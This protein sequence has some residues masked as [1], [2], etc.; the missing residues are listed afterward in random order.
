MSAQESN[1]FAIKKR[2]GWGAVLVSKMCCKI[3]TKYIL[4]LKFDKG[5]SAIT[6]LM[7]ISNKNCLKNP[8]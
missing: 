7:Q 1:D 4:Q 6:L 5:R 3:A 8:L 2:R